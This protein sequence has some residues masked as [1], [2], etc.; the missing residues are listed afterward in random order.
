MSPEVLVIVIAVLIFGFGLGRLYTERARARF[1]MRKTWDGRKGYR[2]GRHLR[3]LVA[4]AVVVAIAGV[5]LASSP[6]V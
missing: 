1:D 4:A 5:V 6:P 3:W 2:Q